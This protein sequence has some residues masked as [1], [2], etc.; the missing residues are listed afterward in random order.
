MREEKGGEEEDVHDEAAAEEADG[1]GEHVERRPWDDGTKMVQK[2]GQKK[3]MERRLKRRKQRRNRKQEEEGNSGEEP[4]QEETKEAMRGR[5]MMM[6]GRSKQTVV[7]ALALAAIV[8]LVLH[9]PLLLLLLFSLCLSPCG[10]FDS[11]IQHGLD[12][13]EI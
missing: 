1:E 7:G 3:G 2:Q 6:R 10:C 12:V 9:F 5:L 11:H 8:C 13:D 4:E